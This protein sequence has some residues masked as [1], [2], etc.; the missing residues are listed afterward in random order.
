MVDYGRFAERLA[1]HR[2]NQDPAKRWD[3]YK[4]FHAE[5]GYVPGGERGPLS[6]ELLETVGRVPEPPDGYDG[7]PGIPAALAEWMALPE[8]ISDD[9]NAGGLECVWPPA[10]CEPDAVGRGYSGP[11][12]AGSPFAVPGSD[13]LRMVTFVADDQ[14][15]FEIAYRSADAV[16]ADPMAFLFLEHRGWAGMAPSITEFALH[17]AASRLPIVQGW[18][19]TPPDEFQDEAMERVRATWPEMG[20][21][22]GREPFGD[23]VLHGGPDAIAMVADPEGTWWDYGFLLNGRTKEGVEAAAVLLGGTDAPLDQW[24][25][26]EGEL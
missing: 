19:A 15:I 3:L 8:N 11:L 23:F 7:L 2:A 26:W 9:G 16:T 4:E 22:V 6:A 24:Y 5:W 1:A 25:V 14:Y 21:P 10:W 12:E 13:D 18:H 17:Q 20:F